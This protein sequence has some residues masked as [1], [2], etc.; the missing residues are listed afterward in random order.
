MS[1]IGRPKGVLDKQKLP[2]SDFEILQSK[3]SYLKIKQ[4]E[5]FSNDMNEAEIRIAWQQ[6]IMAVEAR[7]RQ[8]QIGTCVHPGCCHDQKVLHL[9]NYHY[10]VYRK[11]NPSD[12]KRRMAV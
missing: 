11:N 3:M 2:K 4:S 6:M 10:N 12:H 7:A 8:A 1:K 5:F 9:C